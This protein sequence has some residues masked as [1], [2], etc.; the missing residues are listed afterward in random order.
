MDPINLPLPDKVNAFVNFV[1]GGLHRVRKCESKGHYYQIVPWGSL[2]TYDDNTLTRVVIASH[3]LGVRAEI[4]NH[5]MRGLK[6]LL[7]D[8][9]CREGEFHKRHPTLEKSMESRCI[10]E[11]EKSVL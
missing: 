2:A 1:F 8:R 3:D 11:E 6:I 5:G 4:D 7:H 9:D 10:M